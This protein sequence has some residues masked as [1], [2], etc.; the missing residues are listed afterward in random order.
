M[1]EGHEEFQVEAFKSDVT[2]SELEAMIE[3]WRAQV[4]EARA[5]PPMKLIEA[6]PEKIKQRGN[7]EDR[8]REK[9]RP[10]LCA[11]KR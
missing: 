9:L 2:D 1:V 8:S 5:E 10:R 4:I 6:K 11:W 3:T 7:G